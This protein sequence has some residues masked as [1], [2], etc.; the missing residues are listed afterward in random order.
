MKEDMCNVAYSYDGKYIAASSKTTIALID[1]RKNRVVRR[2]VHPFEVN[3][4]KFDQSGYLFVSAGKQMN[5]HH[6]L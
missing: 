3:G 1:T 5:C 4:I 6:D 2:S